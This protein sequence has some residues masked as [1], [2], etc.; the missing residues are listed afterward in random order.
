MLKYTSKIGAS[1][2][3]RTC[4]CKIP[5]PKKEKIDPFL[6]GRVQIDVQCFSTGGPRTPSGP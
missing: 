6:L 2:Y 3:V 5:K 4:N 1:R